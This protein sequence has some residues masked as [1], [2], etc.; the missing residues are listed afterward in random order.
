MNNSEM[1]LAYGPEAADFTIKEL[2]R[3][4]SLWIIDGKLGILYPDG[5]TEYFDGKEWKYSPWN[6]H[7]IYEYQ[8]NI[9]FIGWVK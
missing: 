9:E 1:L 5:K 7:Y 4:P 3:H 2:R 6:T 8:Y